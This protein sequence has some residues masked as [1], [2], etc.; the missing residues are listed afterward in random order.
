MIEDAFQSKFTDNEF[1]TMLDLKDSPLKITK[2]R[3]HKYESGS[4]TKALVLESDGVKRSE[5]KIT[6]YH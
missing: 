1:S 5:I 3:S 6:P 2:K 4:K